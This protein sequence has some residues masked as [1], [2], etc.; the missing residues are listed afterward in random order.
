YLKLFWT[1]VIKCIKMKISLVQ[2]DIVW[3][4]KKANLEKAQ[5]FVEKAAH[6]KCDLVVFPEMFNTGYSMNV[7]TIAEDED[8]ETASFLSEVSEK[9]AINLI[10]GFSARS[11]N[12]EKGRNLAVAYNRKGEL[13]ARYAKLH[14]FSFAK[15]DQYYIAGS[16][17][18]IF[19][20]DGMSASI[21]ICYDLRFPE[22]FRS[23]ARE[24]QAIFV[25]A[26]WPSTR[27]DH[28]KTLLKARAIENQCFVIGVNR[29]G[30][31]GN[32][33][34]YSGDSCIIDP[35][36]HRICSG[37]ETDEFVIGEINPHDVTEARSG[38][39]FLKDM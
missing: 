31:D 23:V 5:V 21:F 25:I 11:L 6:E 17:A 22:V 9:Y 29:T 13:I 18:V 33:V 4:S 1:A 10:A 26:S 32:G 34:Y 20:I 38:F 15:E 30:K 27:K 36:G 3:E 19:N 35:S 14:P 16:D 28:W 39:P 37:G 24:V 7:S 8:G 2:L 12:G